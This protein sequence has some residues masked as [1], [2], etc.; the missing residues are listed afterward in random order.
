MYHLTYGTNERAECGKL[1]DPSESGAFVATLLDAH[2]RQRPTCASCVSI[3]KGERVSFETAEYLAT[4]AKAVVVI[5]RTEDGREARITTNG[6]TYR[7][8][9]PRTHGKH[10]RAA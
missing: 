7:Y 10:R 9:L 8:L 3:A 1:L 4:D 6:G 5:H 2:A